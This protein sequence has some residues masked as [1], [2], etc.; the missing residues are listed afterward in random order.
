MAK[1]ISVVTGG[2][3]AGFPDDL[4]QESEVAR[5]KNRGPARARHVSPLETAA[6]HLSL[7]PRLGFPRLSIHSTDD[8]QLYTRLYPTPFATQLEVAGFVATDD[9]DCLVVI[10]L[11]VGGAWKEVDRVPGTSTLS[12]AAATFFSGVVDARAAA[13][14]PDT[15]QIDVRLRAT[16]T[17]IDGIT[18]VIPR[19]FDV[20][21]EQVPTEL[22]EVP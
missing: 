17:H 18:V 22:I 7:L 11:F 4:I 13:S 5:L 20:S 21:I 6:Q 12:L 2:V 16:A 8:D 15:S 9:P 10:E 1:Q 3:L 14:T 19:L